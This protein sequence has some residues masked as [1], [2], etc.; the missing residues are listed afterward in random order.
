MH[1]F[2]LY[3]SLAPPFVV[4]SF[5]VKIVIIESIFK[6]VWKLKRNLTNIKIVVNSTTIDQSNN[7]STLKLECSRL[8][9]HRDPHQVFKPKIRCKTKRPC[10]MQKWPKNTFLGWRHVRNLILVIFV[11]LDF[12]YQTK[13]FTNP[14]LRAWWSRRCCTKIQQHWSC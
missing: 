10:H 3:I 9:E 4:L 2:N 11:H 12:C 6:Y 8:I 5:Y 1:F 13:T 14:S 7:W